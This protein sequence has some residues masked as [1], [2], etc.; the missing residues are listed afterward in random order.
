MPIIPAFATI[1][2]VGVKVGDWAKYT[3]IGGWSSI[4]TS[5]AMPEFVKDARNTEWIQINVTKVSYTSI[6]ILVTTQFRDGPKKSTLNVGD[7]RTGSGNLSLQVIAANL[8]EG[9]KLSETEGALTINKT[10]IKPYAKAQRE[11]NYAY[12]KGYVPGEIGEESSVYEFYWDKRSGIIMG[13]SFVNAFESSYFKTI[14]SMIM[15][16]R[17]TNIWQP[18]VSSGL[19]LEWIV[20]AGIIVAAIVLVTSLALKKEGGKKKRH[21]PKVRRRSFH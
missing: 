20:A 5:V 6:T 12:E 7:I 3:V 14:A 17:E 4:N 19:G 8:N 15:E 9:E 16:I 11:V 18:E 21:Q 10:T 13:M 2:T 1:Y